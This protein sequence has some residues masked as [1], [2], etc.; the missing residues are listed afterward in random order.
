MLN[1]YTS[2]SQNNSKHIT[3]VEAD[4]R[5]SLNRT[6]EKSKIIRVRESSEEL[7]YLLSPEP[8]LLD[9]KK[10]VKEKPSE[11]SIWIG[12]NRRWHQTVKTYLTH[13]V[14]VIQVQTNNDWVYVEYVDRECKPKLYSEKTEHSYTEPDWDRSEEY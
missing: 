13:G 11:Y 14:D 12:D 5:V 9:N 10:V 6:N 7:E 8:F 1:S 3:K 2:V 4:Q